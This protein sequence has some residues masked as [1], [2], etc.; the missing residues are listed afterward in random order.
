MIASGLILIV[1]TQRRKDMAKTSQV[2][3]PRDPLYHRLA[4][5][6]LS[7]GAGSCL[8]FFTYGITRRGFPTDFERFVI[9]SA[10]LVSIAA[11][12]LAVVAKG[13]WY[14]RVPALLLNCVSILLWFVLMI[15]A[16][17]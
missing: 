7:I 4:L 17:I 2:T 5:L 1:L 11:L 16:G 6:S 14:L 3:D 10:L 13:Y 8:L 15:G 12:I 9:G